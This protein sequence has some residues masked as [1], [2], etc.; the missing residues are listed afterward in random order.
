MEYMLSG[1]P[2]LLY[3]LSGIPD[4]YYN[5]LFT[6]EGDMPAD[7]TRNIRQILNKSPEE[8]V[9]FGAKAQK[10]VLTKKNQAVQSQKII[11]LISKN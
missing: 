3:R 11:D 8:L 6:I 10:F 9:A 1:I 5:Y 7:I 2:K 4:E